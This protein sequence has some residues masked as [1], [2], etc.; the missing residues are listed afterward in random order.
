MGF[1]VWEESGNGVQISGERGDE[2]VAQKHKE[3]PQMGVGEA[4]S[5]LYWCWPCW[6]LIWPFS[7]NGSENP[8]VVGCEYNGKSQDCEVTVNQGISRNVNKTHETT[9]RMQVYMVSP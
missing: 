3:E 4:P 1:Q 8:D 7:S 9:K 6:D 2:E 5:K